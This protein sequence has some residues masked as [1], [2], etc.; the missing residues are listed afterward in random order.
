MNN[1]ANYSLISAGKDDAFGTMDDEI[2][3]LQSPAYSGAKPPPSIWPTARCNLVNTFSI[4]GTVTD[5]AGNPVSPSISRNFSIVQLGSFNVENRTNDTASAATSLSLNVVNTPDGSFQPVANYGAGVNPY[6]VLAGHFNG[7][8]NLDLAVANVSSDNVSI[9]LGKGDGTFGSTTNFPAANG[10][11]A[12]AV[13]D[14]NGDSFADLVSANIYNNSV[15]VLRGRGD[16]SFLSPTNYAVGGS[17]RSVKLGD[18]NQDGRLDIVT[19]NSGSGNI[20]ILFG[21]TNGTFQSASNIVTGAGAH[22]VALGHFNGDGFLDI[23]VVNQSPNT[24]TILL[25]NG[26]G[27]FAPPID[28]P[29]ANNPRSVVLGDWNGDSFLDVATVGSGNIVSVLFG[30][31]AG[32]FTPAVSYPTGSSDPY[33]IVAADFNADGSL[34]LGVANYSGSRVSIFL[35]N[36]LGIF[37]G[38]ANYFVS[39][40]PIALA[41]GDFDGDGRLEIATANYGGNNVTLLRPN[42]TQLLAED[43]SGSGIR[44][45]SGRGNLSTTADNDYWSFTGRTGER[46]VVASETPGNLNNS[47]LN[48]IIERPD[49]STLTS[50]VS[51]NGTGQSVPVTLP[52]SGTY[53]VRVASYHNYSGEYRLRVTLAPAP[54]QL[55]GEDN[56][57]VSQANVPAFSRQGATQSAQILGYIR[58]GDPGDVFALSYAPL[59]RAEPVLTLPGKQ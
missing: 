15:S 18:L 53:F 41:P 40:N 46:L 9:L 23:A 56:N 42:P 44:T 17:P 13:A 4:A 30:D 2:Y 16:G 24:L 59:G 45:G 50:F 21:N 8:T 52:V 37:S 55:E 10:A 32:N 12:L 11:I 48:Y 39:G 14:L 22:G 43:P 34:D 5:R 51:N 20:S 7:D 54:W 35:N 25:G 19:A 33:H 38:S 58:A 1:L 26:G 57:N 3:P 6:F 27:S 28:L 49:G 36:G 29:V 31:G 47:G